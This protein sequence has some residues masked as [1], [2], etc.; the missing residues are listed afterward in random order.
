MKKKKVIY[1]ELQYVTKNIKMSRKVHCRMKSV[2]TPPPPPPS[3][4]CQLNCSVEGKRTKDLTVK[5]EM[6]GI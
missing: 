3:L 2:L 1:F 5:F 4:L 6:N